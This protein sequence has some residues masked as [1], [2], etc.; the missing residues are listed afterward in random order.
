MACLYKPYTVSLD[1]LGTGLVAVNVFTDAAAALKR[2]SRSAIPASST[3][4][5]RKARDA[6]HSADLEQREGKREMYVEARG[7]GVELV[8]LSVHD[9]HKHERPP[10]FFRHFSISTPRTARRTRAQPALA[11]SCLASGFAAL[12]RVP[13]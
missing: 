11:H 9:V 7:A 13:P 4:H 3:L 6:F 5:T 1:S 10:R 12:P 2:A 8:R